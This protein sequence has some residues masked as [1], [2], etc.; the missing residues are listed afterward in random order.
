MATEGEEMIDIEK[1]MT[2]HFKPEQ[3]TIFGLERP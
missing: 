3:N 1:E 2:N